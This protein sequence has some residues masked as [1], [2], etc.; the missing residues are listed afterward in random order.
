MY[1][2]KILSLIHTI[3]S[4]KLVSPLIS[5]VI[6]HGQY[7]ARFLPNLFTS[8]SERLEG[9]RSPWT[10]RLAI[11]FGFTHHHITEFTLSALVIALH[12]N[13]V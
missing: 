9:N 8:Y 6:P 13:V 5:L 4:P 7:I 2:T 12:F 3:G 10:L 11:T 1:H